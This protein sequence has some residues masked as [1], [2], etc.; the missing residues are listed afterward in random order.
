MYNDTQNIH[1]SSIQQ[2]IT[3]STQN[4]LKLNSSS[5]DCNYLD[6]SA[7]S[8]QTK[9]LLVE[10]ISDNSVHSILDITFGELFKQIMFHVSQFN[11]EIQIE[12]KK[13][14]GEE[15]EDAECKCFTGR[16]TRLVNSLSGFSDLIIINI[17][18]S[19]EIGNIISLA[20]MKST[21]T[22]TFEI[23]EHV[24]RE[25]AEREYGYSEEKINE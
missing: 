11:K 8:V 22:N 2:S 5:F 7:F 6:D 17:S 16:I 1:T 10:Y 3:Q 4:L 25:M 18:E 13:R 14:I 24:R 9:Q 23:K 19:E 20:K 15:I 12:I 21:L